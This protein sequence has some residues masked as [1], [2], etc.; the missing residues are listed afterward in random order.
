MDI[1]HP[2]HT[3]AS[4]NPLAPWNQPD[5]DELECEDCGG[6]MEAECPDCKKPMCDGCDGDRCPACHRK[7]L[8]DEQSGPIPPA[9]PGCSADL[10]VDGALVEYDYLPVVY[11]GRRLPDGEWENDGNGF[12]WHDQDGSDRDLTC[13]ECELSVVPSDNVRVERQALLEM[14]NIVLAAAEINGAP[15]AWV[16]MGAAILLERA[17]GES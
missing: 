11:G 8:V 6:E 9:C 16:G 1:E 14:E 2:D 17:A 4:A 7:K 13:S 3:G 15:D 10:T 12:E 5:T